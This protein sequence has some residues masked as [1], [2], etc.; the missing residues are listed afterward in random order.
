MCGIFVSLDSEGTL[1]S[2]CQPRKEMKIGK[3]RKG[4]LKE[5]ISR[6]N[7]KIKKIMNEIKNE[8]LCGC[9]GGAP[10]Y[11]CFSGKGCPKRLA[12]NEDPYIESFVEVIKYVEKNIS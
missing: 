9:L 3:I 2:T 5:L 7:S 11:H 10:E 4:N 8:S 12:G 1:Y 6:H